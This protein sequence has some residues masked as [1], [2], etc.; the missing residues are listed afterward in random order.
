MCVFFSR[1]FF[2]YFSENVHVFCVLC[3]SLVSAKKGGEITLLL[4]QF[5]VFL[6]KRLN[7]VCV[8]CYVIASRISFKS[9]HQTKLCFEC[10]GC[11]HI[12]DAKIQNAFLSFIL[13]N[14]GKTDDKCVKFV[15][16]LIDSWFVSLN[17]FILN[18]HR[19][20]FSLS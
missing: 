10:S 4:I 6:S 9:M 5:N 18:I 3:S 20:R 16:V 12:F 15:R 17:L 11:V 13:C 2:G 14:A 1:C 7:C 19:D 8:F